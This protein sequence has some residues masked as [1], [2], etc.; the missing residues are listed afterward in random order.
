MLASGTKPSASGKHQISLEAERGKG[1][2]TRQSA[3]SNQRVTKSVIIPL[4]FM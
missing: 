2:L 4:M 3:K 1:Q